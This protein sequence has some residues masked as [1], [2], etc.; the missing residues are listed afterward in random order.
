MQI[1][2]QTAAWAYVNF[3]IAGAVTAATVAASYPVAPGGVVVLTIADEV[4]GA[5]VIL[6]A[7]AT[8]A[9]VTFTRG[10]GL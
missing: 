10:S 5:T 4:T 9:S 6:A 2:N 1:A 3:G 8:S 7:G